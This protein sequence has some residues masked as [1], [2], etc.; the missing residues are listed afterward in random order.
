MLYNRAKKM[1]LIHV[2]KRELGLTDDEYRA[3]LFGAAGVESAKEIKNE[4]QYFDVMHTFKQVGFKPTVNTVQNKKLKYK[5]TGDSRVHWRISHEQEYYIRG[6]WDLAS[7]VHDEDSLRAII[8]RIVK[9]DDIS[10]LSKAQATKVILALRDICEKAGYNPD[11][12][13]G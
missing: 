6:L 2:A 7:R 5:I 13:W 1:Q 9:T 3:L 11:S 12:K 10:W 4:K 8:K